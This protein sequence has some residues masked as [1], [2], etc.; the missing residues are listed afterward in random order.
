MGQQ[1]HQ[2]RHEVPGTR[3]HTEWKNFLSLWLILSSCDSR[4]L[5]FWKKNL[6]LCFCVVPRRVHVE[7]TAFRL[8]LAWTKCLLH[9]VLHTHCWLKFRPTSGT[10]WSTQCCWASAPLNLWVHTS[11]SH[12]AFYLMLWLIFWGLSHTV[13]CDKRAQSLNLCSSGKG[14]CLILNYSFF[15]L[16][17]IW[18]NTELPFYTIYISWMTSLF[19]SF[20]I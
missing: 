3:L 14:L 19:N 9:P 20:Q 7:C 6:P 10:A 18:K 11:A 4:W 12:P 17:G 13:F 5:V 1:E 2:P 8:M 15:Y 16:A